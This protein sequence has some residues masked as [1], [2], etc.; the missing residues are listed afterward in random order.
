MEKNKK[1]S[2]VKENENEKTKYIAMK[3]LKIDGIT[4]KKYQ[5]IEDAEKLSTFRQLKNLEWIKKV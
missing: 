3:E 4:I 2:K 1:G 5:I